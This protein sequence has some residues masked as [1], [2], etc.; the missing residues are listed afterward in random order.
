MKKLVILLAIALVPFLSEAKNLWAYLTYTTFNSPQGP[1]VE[2][3]LSIQ[4]NSVRFLKT[5]DGKF[6]AFADIVMTFKDNGVIKAFKKYELKSP[7]IPDTSKMD[8]NFLDVQ[9]FQVPNGTYDFE[10]QISDKN[11]DVKPVPFSQ[12]I[13]VDYP[14]DKPVFSGIQ[15]IDSYTKTTTENILSKSGFDLVPHVLTFYPPTQKKLSFYCEFYN[16]DK[17]L[18][19]DQKYIFNY[20]LESFEN[21]TK[22]PEFAGVRKV[23][24]HAYE[25]LLSDINIDHLATGNY[26]L[27]V[28]ARNQKN[29]LVASRKVFIQRSNPNAKLSFTDLVALNPTNTFVDK[30]TKLDSL[31]EF[32][33]STYPISSG[34]ERAFINDAMKS[35]DMERLKNYFYGFWLRRDNK[36]PESAWLAYK[37]EVHKVNFNFKTQVKKGYQT[38]RGMVYLEYGP[39]NTR[40]EHVMEP[41][42]LPYEIWQYYTLKNNQRN[43]KFIFYS[44]DVVTGDYFLIHSDAIG[45]VNNP[46][47]QM[48]LHDKTIAPRDIQDSQ[49]INSWGDDTESTWSLPN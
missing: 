19:A 38:D 33:S 2:T 25:V 24:A 1:F 29:E 22:Y 41:N 8:F 32:I 49:I 21:N 17:S 6:Q 18:G 46:S 16:A 44:P 10:I 11:K 13:V 35:M 28:E 14:Q 9:R 42:T 12:Q 30:I 26:N 3:Y 4:G 27:V 31:K 7:L 5:E 43:R 15:L 34:L 39:P 37:A 36:N 48:L 45:E 40:S 20:Y 23:S 47:W